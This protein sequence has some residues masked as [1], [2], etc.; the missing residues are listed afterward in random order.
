M[1][2][3]RT[4]KICKECFSAFS[5]PLRNGVRQYIISARAW[6]KRQFCSHKCGNAEKVRKNAQKMR[7]V[8]VPR[9]LVEK[10]VAP[11]RGR[12]RS[13]FS[14]EWRENLSKSHI[15]QVA[16]NTGKKVPQM[17]GEN[18]PRWILDRTKL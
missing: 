6:E 10:R 13:P 16:W 2:T 3:E 11:L 4:E 17:T 7:G 18:H 12:K 15:G 9:D 1:R 5:C 14:E 8:P